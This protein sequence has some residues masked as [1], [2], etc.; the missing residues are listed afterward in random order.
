MMARILLFFLLGATALVSYAAPSRLDSLLLDLPT[1]PPDSHRVKALL[2][3]GS[4]Y[5]GQS[6]HLEGLTYLEEARDLGDSLSLTEPLFRVYN[7]LV[8]VHSRLED[9]PAALEYCDRMLD[10]GQATGDRWS[11]YRAIRVTGMVN[12]QAKDFPAAYDYFGRA[13]DIAVEE[14]WE[15]E[16][17]ALVHNQGT[18]LL[19]QKKW[20]EA[21]QIF[22]QNL[23]AFEAQEHTF[24][25]AVTHN[26]LGRCHFNLED[27]E[28]ALAEY[29]L[30]LVYKKKAGN[31]ISM[32]A[33]RQNIGEVLVYLGRYEEATEIL[34]SAAA[35]ADTLGV[36]GLVIDAK[37][38]LAN[39][40]ARQG[41]FEPA[42]DFLRDH[43]ALKDSML[44]ERDQ[45]KMDRLRET[46]RYKN[47][48]LEIADLQTENERE[49]ARNTV[50]NTVI[51]LGSAALGIVLVLLGL[52]GWSARK[53]KKANEE[54]ARQHALIAAQKGE[55]EQKNA[56][57][58][59]QNQALEAL[60]R[61]K[62]GLLGMMAHDLKAPLIKTI[63]LM[64]VARQSNGVGEQEDRMLGM[65]ERSCQ[66]GLELID[67]LL[68]LNRMD[69]NAD[70]LA[71]EALS[72]GELVREKRDEFGEAAGKKGIEIELV[73]GLPEGMVSGHR[74]Y[75]GRILDNLISNAI[76]FSPAGGEVRLAA[77]QDAA[78]YWLK[79]A[80][81]GPGF[82]EA[83]KAKMFRNFQRLS[84]RPTGGEGST[85]LGLAIVKHLVDR[86]GGTIE[87]VSEK[88]KGADFLLR[89]AEEKGS[90]VINPE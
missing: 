64:E 69:R 46:I 12:M 51:R 52:L 3:I 86:L 14:E 30:A 13:R 25:I 68:E 79:V 59:K 11:Q 76:K 83:D 54:L 71:L 36:P 65:A 75:L 45:A 19:R 18:S 23:P 85:G 41:Q 84:A 72:L 53:R 1:M 44:Q 31:P 37:D 47:Q 87:L 81:T 17:P 57:L 10:L 43:I 29:E 77:G 21:I 74:V 70:E 73:G 22:T 80:D 15:D 40:Y 24:G 7:K 20:E 4:I 27:Y 34:L 33:T 82:S 38:R 58:T 48:E 66:S 56:A 90:L 5:Y 63:S 42:Y 8:D 55:I 39:L 49:V 32:Q 6:E 28:K 9:F 2:E 35:A 61:E 50:Q 16:V 67:D 88:G 26:N 62:D 60:N 89:F 78:G